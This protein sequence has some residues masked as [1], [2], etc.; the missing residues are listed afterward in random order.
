MGLTLSP[1]RASLYVGCS[2]QAVYEVDTATM[3]VTRTF[4]TVPFPDVLVMLP[5]QSKLYALG[6]YGSRLSVINLSSGS[7][8]TVVVPNAASNYGI[9]LDPTG[10][11][12]FISDMGRIHV[13][14][15]TTDQKI[16]E[17]PSV[18][19]GDIA[20]TPDGSHVATAD[21]NGGGL[22]VVELASGAS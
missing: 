16:Q 4:P 2:N 5:D 3:T 21:G 7:V 11:R 9:A 15:A 6:R 20:V 8:D 13:L 14:D 19:F 10:S 12:V 17:F 22:W 18:T 1:D